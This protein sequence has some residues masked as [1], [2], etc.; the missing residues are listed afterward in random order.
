MKTK[1]TSFLRRKNFKAQALLFLC[2]IS[3]FS[4]KGQNLIWAK[5]INGSDVRAKGMV[6]DGSGNVYTT[7]TFSG[8]TDFDPGPGIF[9]VAPQPNTTNVF[10]SKLDASGNF[11]WA[12][13]MAMNGG[14]N[15]GDG[16][17]VALDASGNIY[18]TGTFAGTVDFDPGPGTFTLNSTGGAAFIWKLNPSGNFTMAKNFGGVGLSIKLDAS[19]NI[20]TTGAFVGSEDFDP[21]VGTFS[22]TSAG[23]DD[24]FISKLDASGNFV[25]AK[26]FGGTQT[27]DGYG[28]T[29]DASGNVYTTGNFMSVVDFDPGAGTYTLSGSPNYDIFISKLD[30]TGNF[31]WAKKKGSSL[32]IGSSIALDASGNPYVTGIDFTDGFISKLDPSGNFTWTKNLGRSVSSIA[33]D[34]SGN[35]YSSGWFSGTLDFDPGA[36]TYTLTSAG[37]E[38][39]FVS[40]LDASGNFIM[41]AAM[42][43]TSTD[44]GYAVGFD[45]LGNV[46][47]AGVFV[48]PA[49]FDPTAGVFNLNAISPNLNMFVTKIS[50]AS[51][52]GLIENISINNIVSVY[53]NPF[54]SQINIEVKENNIGNEKNLVIYNS[55]GQTVLSENFN[56]K[57]ITIESKHLSNGIYFYKL[58]TNNKVIGSGKLI[59]E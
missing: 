8:T 59:A 45:A 26:G 46:T 18:A 23:G 36:G 21:G 4:H 57:N 48:G 47:S 50:A 32:G 25:W 54:S 15:T 14:N 20:Y 13:T 17:S 12:K 22:L 55:L 31:V 30:A 42:G 33:L 1:T 51:P 9:T 24:V 28:I 16:R 52:T 41:A 40:K 34:G 27:D 44:R 29:V 11:V 6:V 56:T 2:L 38:D 49:D 37:A 35:I 53:P 43:G 7:G 39:V 3:F 58:S 19:G 5:A 10:I